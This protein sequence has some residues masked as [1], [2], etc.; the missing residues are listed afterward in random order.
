MAADVGIATPERG[1]APRVRTIDTDRFRWLLLDRARARAA[2]RSSTSTR[3][4]GSRSTTRPAEASLQER[5]PASATRP[6]PRS[7]ASSTTR[8]SE[9][10]TQV[11]REIDAAFREV[12]A[13]RTGCARACGEPIGWSGSRRG[14]GCRSASTTRARGGGARV[15]ACSSRRTRASA[16]PPTPCRRFRCRALARRRRRALARRSGHRPRG[17]RRGPADEVPRHEPARAGRRRARGWAVLD[18]PRAELGHRL[19]PLRERD[20]RSSSS[21]TGSRSPWMLVF[22][23]RSGSRHPSCRSRSAS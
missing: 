5:R 22:F 21:L 1:E 17:A 18:P 3:T 8:S 23:A 20:R 12:E 16:P 7:T 13:A 19:R 9:Y 15:T 6:P 10:S 11:L 2:P 4:T 14:R